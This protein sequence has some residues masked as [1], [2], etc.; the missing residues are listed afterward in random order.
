MFR[1]FFFTAKNCGLQCQS[2]SRSTGLS[3]ARGSQCRRF[4]GTL[5]TL[6]YLWKRKHWLTDM[7]V[8]AKALEALLNGVDHYHHHHLGGLGGQQEELLRSKSLPADF[9]CFSDTGRYTLTHTQNSCCSLHLMLENLFA[10]FAVSAKTCWD[11]F[12]YLFVCHLGQ[13]VT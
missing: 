1:M 11:F 4:A 13:D 2:C 12:I 10:V 8:D 9:R 3:V 6:P 5:F 7:L